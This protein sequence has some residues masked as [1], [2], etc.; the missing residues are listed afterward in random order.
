MLIIEGAEGDCGGN[1]VQTE[2][3]IITTVDGD[4]NVESQYINTTTVNTEN[5]L[6]E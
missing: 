1:I 2:L 6:I 3:F 5:I 4:G